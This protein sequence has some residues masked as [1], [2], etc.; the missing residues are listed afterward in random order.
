MKFLFGEPSLKIKTETDED[1][2][3]FGLKTDFIIH[4]IKSNPVPQTFDSDAVDIFSREE[5]LARYA[6]EFVPKFPKL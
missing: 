3:V 5:N 4:A 1:F 6:I 2:N